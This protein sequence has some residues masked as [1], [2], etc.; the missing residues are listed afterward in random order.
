MSKEEKQRLDEKIQKMDLSDKSYQWIYD[1]L[2]GK[3]HP[4]DIVKS[5]HRT[6]VVPQYALSGTFNRNNQ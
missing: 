4:D 3:Y 6:Q 1:Q 5:L 2:G